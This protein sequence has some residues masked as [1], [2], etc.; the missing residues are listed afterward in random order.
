MHKVKIT[1]NPRD[2][3]QKELLHFCQMISD[4]TRQN[5]GCS[6]SCMLQDKNCIVLDQKWKQFNLLEDYFLSDSF[7]ALLGAMK[8]RSEERRVGKEC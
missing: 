6:L 1:I 4:Q 3:K 2:D 7:S 8:F 5:A